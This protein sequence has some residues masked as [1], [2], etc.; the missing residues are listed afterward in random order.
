MAKRKVTIDVEDDEGAVFR[1][2]VTGKVTREKILKVFETMNLVDVE[3][4]PEGQTPDSVGGRIW[5][6][7]ERNY[8][9]GKF[10]SSTILEKYEDEYNLPIK[11]SV[12][13]TYLAR[14]T[15]RGRLTRTRNGR[16]WSY[17]AADRAILPQRLPLTTPR[18]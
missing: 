1:M 11:L 6:I 14:F 17:R 9:I 4:P 2:T 18:P 13:S 15:H 10:T 5:A 7:V 3:A 8:P 12:I 16:E